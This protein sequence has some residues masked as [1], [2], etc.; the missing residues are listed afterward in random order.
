MVGLRIE[1]TLID[2][3]IIELLRRHGPGKLTQR[4]IADALKIHENTARHSV[5]RLEKTG[6][7]TRIVRGRAGTNYEVINASN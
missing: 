3:K 4:E 5:Q 2:E 6:R 1:V 7:I